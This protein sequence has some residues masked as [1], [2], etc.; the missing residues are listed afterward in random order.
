M[1]VTFQI[2]SEEFYTTGKSIVDLGW[3]EVQPWKQV[4]LKEML[5]VKRGDTLQ[6][7]SVRFHSYQLVTLVLKIVY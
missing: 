6:I 2:Q 1:T 3:T 5:E 4:D 7:S